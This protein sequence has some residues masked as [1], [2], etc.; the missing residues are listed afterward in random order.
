MYRTYL[1]VFLFLIFPYAKKLSAQISQ[2]DVTNKNILFHRLTTEQGL[3]HDYINCVLQDSNGFLWIG[4]VNGL[5]RYDGSRIISFKNDANLPH[6]ISD[7]NITCLSMDSF[8]RVWA[9]TYWQG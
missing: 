8:H 7:N 4:T 3:S 2:P 6:S 9:G 1:L 5:C